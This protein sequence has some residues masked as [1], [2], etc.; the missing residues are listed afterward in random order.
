MVELDQILQQ[1][2]LQVFRLFEKRMF[3]LSLGRQQVCA[4]SELGFGAIGVVFPGQCYVAE[5][6]IDFLMFCTTLAIK[7]NLHDDNLTL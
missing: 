6:C 7:Q 4:F 3:R 2:W 1:T 5:H